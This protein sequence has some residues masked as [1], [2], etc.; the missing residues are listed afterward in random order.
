MAIRE[1]AEI[2]QDRQT[3]AL[4]AATIYAASAAGAKPFSD[5]EKKEHMN[6]A[7][8]HAELLWAELEARSS[9]PDLPTIELETGN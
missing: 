6:Y 3:L 2:R 7:I 8:D 9:N 1:K 4:M 5:E